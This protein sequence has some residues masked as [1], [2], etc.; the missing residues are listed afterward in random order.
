MT[1]D[2]VENTVTL[3]EQLAAF[4]A[5]HQ[6]KSLT[7]LGHLWRYISCGEGRDVLLLLEGAGANAEVEFQRILKFEKKRR[8][9]SVSYPETAFAM[10]HLTAG[11]MAILEAEGVRTAAIH[12]HSLGAALAQ[13]FVREYPEKVSEL[14]LANIGVA[15]ARRI[16]LARILS[17]CLSVL[18]GAL[19]GPMTKSMLTRNL[20]L[21]PEQER[22][23]YREYFSKMVGLYLTKQLIVNQFRCL[24]DFIDNYPLKT[25]DLQNWGGRVLIMEAEDDRGWNASE[26]TALKNLYPGAQVHTFSEGG[27]MVNMTRRNEY[28]AILNEFLEVTK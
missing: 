25:E 22:A 14:I 9:I 1:T 27:H 19:I 24:I 23:F 7:S 17:H 8:V 28:D 21:L 2:A 20:S 15:G 12:G 18:P 6:V 3:E 4:R 16:M 11:V 26:R 5:A 13:C 10:Q